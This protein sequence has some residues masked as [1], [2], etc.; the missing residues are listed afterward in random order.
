MCC[1]L[2]NTM[3]RERIMETQLSIGGMNCGHCAQA[4]RDA[5]AKVPGVDRVIE[6][7]LDA[8]RATVSGAAAAERL[9]AA[10]AAAGFE[11]TVD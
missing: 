4:V 7:N 8:G 9:V 11:A 6:V 3:E 1:V 5:L 2:A 10:V